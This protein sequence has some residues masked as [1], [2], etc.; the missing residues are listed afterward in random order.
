MRAKVALVCAALCVSAQARAGTCIE[1]YGAI[2]RE[3]MYCG[4]FCDQDKLLPLQQVYEANC[5]SFVVPLSALPMETPLEQLPASV[6]HAKPAAHT[7]LPDEAPAAS[8]IDEV[9]W[10]L[11][12]WPRSPLSEFAYN[13]K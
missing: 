4:F 11:T 6:F 1:L 5:I 13:A 12:R 10:E 9:G 8:T 3:A 2:K 7:M